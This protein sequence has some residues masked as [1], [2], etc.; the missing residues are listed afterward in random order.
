[1]KEDEKMMRH[2][3]KKS[4]QLLLVLTIIFLFVFNLY[5]SRG[6]AIIA[7][8][9]TI[10]L[11]DI[12][13]V[14]NGKKDEGSFFL[15]TVTTRTLNLPLLIYAMLDPHV[16]IQRKE[17]VI[18]PG[19]TTKEYMDYMTKWMQESQKIAEVVALR[20]AGYNPKISGDGAE[21]VGIMPNSPSK[22]KLVQGDIIKKGDKQPVSSGEEVS[23]KVSQ[24]DIGEMVELEIERQGETMTL[25]L[26]T[27]ESESE[28]GK[29][30]VGVYITT[31]NWKPELPLKIEIN[32][33]KIGG[34]SAGS[35]FVMEILNQL[36]PEDLTKGRKIAGTGTISLDE[37]IGEIGGVEQ[38][39][40]AAYRAGAEIFFVPEK[41]AEAA[42]KAAEGLEIEVV[43]VKQLD[44]IL[45]YLNEL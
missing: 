2:F 3:R 34:P 4:L 22:G 31:L 30:I 19:W 25:S 11:K 33:G 44:D 17:Q 43:P 42:M 45:N 12:V 36:T 28:P 21:I 5:L 32:T 26:P 24:R 1:V 37:K 27:I 23:E 20:K 8:G 35:M 10:D 9:V 14:E 39:V 6:Y 16:E 13:T 38:K 18:P 40:V 7:P 41:N 29:A 15:T